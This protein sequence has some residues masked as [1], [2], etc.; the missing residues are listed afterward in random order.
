MSEALKIPDAANMRVDIYVREKSRLESKL[1]EAENAIVATEEEGELVLLSAT[2][3]ELQ[4]QLSILV[5][6]HQAGR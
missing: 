1:T 5:A 2:I 6:Q 4:K 3:K